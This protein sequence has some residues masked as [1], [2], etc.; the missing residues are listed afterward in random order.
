MPASPT[1]NGMIQAVPIRA[2]IIIASKGRPELVPLMLEQ[3]EAQSQ[4]PARVIYSVH[5]ESD[6]GARP[7]CT[8]PVEYVFGPPGS[9]IQRNSALRT[10]GDGID[11]VIFFDDDFVP[12]K[13]WVERVLA[14][15]ERLDVVAVTGHVVWDGAQSPGTSWSAGLEIVVARD[16]AVSAG[17]A[18]EPDLRENAILYGCNMAMRLSALR[19][20][21]FDERLVLYGWL[22]D[23][24][25]S[26]RL[27]K[28]GKVCTT[29]D[30]WGVHLGMKTGRTSGVRLG[31]SQV[32]NP[33]YLHH[34]GTMTCRQA[35]G[36]ILRPLAANLV[37]SFF[38]EEYIDRRGRLKGNLLG[39]LELFRYR[40]NCRPEYAA[41]L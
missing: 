27:S 41:S 37:K 11:V 7:T 24:D 3:L 20:I 4:R 18:V 33:W 1:S 22:E 13:F 23:R 29:R 25:V 34:K 17:A 38:P 12:S 21:G 32:V 35:A 14:I 40:K 6:I 10:L 15:F 16:A 19:D 30:V 5:Q 39:L 31:Y 2:A 8:L 36:S 26:V 28:L 9:T